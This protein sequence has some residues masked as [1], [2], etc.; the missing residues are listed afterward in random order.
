MHH[1]N[2]KKNKKKKIG[3]DYKKDKFGG[4]QGINNKGET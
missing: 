2:V 3:K 4:H 1:V